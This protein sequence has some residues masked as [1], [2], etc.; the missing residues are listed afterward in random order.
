VVGLGID[1]NYVASDQL[2]LLPVTNRFIFLEE[3]DLVDVTVDAVTLTDADGE[4]AERTVHELDGTHEDADKGPYRHYMQRKS[5]SSPPPSSAPWKDVSI[6][7][8]R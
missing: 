1:E 7:P 8:T 5:S 6:R 4:P 3:G 2:A